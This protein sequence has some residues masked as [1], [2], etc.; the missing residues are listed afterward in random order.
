[1]ND[2]DIGVEH[3][4]HE[5]APPPEEAAAGTPDDTLSAGVFLT[6]PVAPWPADQPVPGHYTRRLVAGW[7]RASPNLRSSVLMIAAFGFFAIMMT[8]IKLAGARLPL[9]QILVVRQVIVLALLALIVGHGLHGVMRTQRPGLQALR[10]LFSFGA[11]FGGFLAIINLPMAEATALGFSQVL[12]VTLGAILFLG[13]R[14]DARRW[15]AM[16]VG[17]VGVLIILR[18]TSQ[19]LSLYAISALV[20][21]LFG[22][23]ITVTVR[24]LGN[25]ER[26]ET[27]LFWQGTLMLLVLVVPSWWVW[28][29]P[30]ARE[31]TWLLGLGLVG[32]AGQWLITRAY[33]QGEASALAP[34]DFVRLILATGSGFLVFGEIPDL[35]TIAGAS[36]VVLGTL[37]TVRRNSEKPPAPVE[38]AELEGARP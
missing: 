14:V 11:M 28:V 4:L 37:Y 26:T 38:A 18:P 2:R 10:A 3:G 35:V 25:T 7:H 23:G 16:L 27:I 20:G 30:T 29:P 19:A 32:T 22:A 17:F 15:C 36:L 13:E 24:M 1:M 9:V 5:I 6:Q 33:Q 8:L 12:F 31:W 34:L 21:A